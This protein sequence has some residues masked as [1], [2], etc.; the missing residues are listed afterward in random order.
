MERTRR[1]NTRAA[2][3]VA[4]MGG[5]MLPAQGGAQTG[6]VKATLQIEAA[7]EA[8][9]TLE[10][11]LGEGRMRLDM[12]D[13]MSIVSTESPQ[14]MLMIQHPD[15]RYIEWGPD[16]LRM[17]QQ[18]MQR[19]PG[20]G[21]NEAD[22]FDPGSVSFE[23]TGQRAQI[24]TWDAFEVL[25]TSED[26]EQ[27]LWLTTDTDVGLFELSLRAAQA[28]SALRMP[29]A[30][31]GAPTA[32]T[33]ARYREV[34]TAQGLPDGR[35]VRIVDPERSTTLTLQ[36]VEIGPLDEATWSAPADYDRMEMPSIPGLP[37]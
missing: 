6:D 12:S 5:L 27:R 15:R 36:D 28:L 26:G 37:G 13:Q 30:G 1:V 23:E 11:S 22:P 35:V 7:D 33:L 17:M 21:G 19:M 25:M 10:Y 34:A 31:G 16:Q 24:G 3:V 8:P 18:M 29:M 4:V 9:M 14:S 32:Q 20:G 2:A